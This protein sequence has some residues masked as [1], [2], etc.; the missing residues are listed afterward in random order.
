MH[1]VSNSKGY[2]NSV[3]AINR[4][5]KHNKANYTFLYAGSADKEEAAKVLPMLNEIISYPTAIFL[6][7]NK[8]VV[9]IHTG[10]SGPGTGTHFNELSKEFTITIESL[11]FE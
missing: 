3:K 10:F 4:F 5:K 7:K 6:S 11:L 8:E 2:E 1:F 9:K